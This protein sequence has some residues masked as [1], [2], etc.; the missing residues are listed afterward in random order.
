MKF[1]EKYDKEVGC[2]IAT[3]FYKNMNREYHIIE[4]PRDY[5]AIPD[6][7]DDDIIIDPPQFAPDSINKQIVPTIIPTI[8][9][10]APINIITDPDGSRYKPGNVHKLRIRLCDGTDANGKLCTTPARKGGFCRKHGENGTG[11]AREDK[12]PLGT[13]RINKEG[14]REKHD[15]RNW[16][17]MCQVID[18]TGPCQNV[19]P[20]YLCIKHKMAAKNNKVRSA[21]DAALPNA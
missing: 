9:P 21:A 13:E 18:E 7:L 2:V 6:D 12:P 20:T 4:M 17:K 15:G 5:N 10:I 1:I 11:K 8:T 3:P 19:S 16:R 14:M